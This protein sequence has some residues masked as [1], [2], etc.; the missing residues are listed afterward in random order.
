MMA[1]QGAI[2]ASLDQTL[3]SSGDRIDAGLQSVGDLAVAP[4]LAGVRGVG[5]Q[6]DTRFQLLPRRVFPF[7]IIAFSWLRSS[8]LSVTTYFLTA[9]T[10]L[11]T[12]PLRCWADPSSQRSTANQGSGVLAA[13]RR[14]TPGDA[15]MR[16][17]PTTACP[18]ARRHESNHRTFLPLGLRSGMSLI[19]GE[20]HPPLSSHPAPSA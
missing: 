2:Q 13:P 20:L 10:F 5:F 19:C 9:T 17:T 3:T 11:T 1:L 6:Q 8:S 15:L 4:S 16:M 7:L 18:I 12:D 14:C